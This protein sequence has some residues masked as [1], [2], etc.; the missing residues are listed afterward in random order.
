MAADDGMGMQGIHFRIEELLA[1]TDGTL[2]L[3]GAGGKDT[4]LTG[5]RDDSRVVGP[6]DLFLAIPGEKVDG[7]RYIGKALAAGAAAVCAGRPLCVADAETALRR[8]VP[9]VLVA[10]PLAAFQA[11]AQ[12]HRRRFPGLL[13]AG[14]T[15]SSGKTSTKEMIAAVLEQR[16]PGAVLKTE[17]NTNNHFGVPRNLLRLT[18]DHR[19]A[20]I[21]M[22]SN[23]P[24]EIALLARLAEPEIGVVSNIG[25]AHLEF[26]GSLEGVAR[27]K[28]DL[29]RHTAWSGI[30]VFPGEA[31]HVD[32]LRAGSA[33]R[34]T[35]T[36]G[37]GPDNDVRVRYHGPVPD[38]FR[39][40]LTWALTGRTE[41]FSWGIGGEHQAM[42]A[43]AAAAAGT[44]AGLSPEEIVKGLRTCRLPG[45]RM[46]VLS[47]QGVHWVN[48]AYN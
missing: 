13:V 21:E 12:A 14:I 40:S 11:L 32:V 27:E 47:W 4:L 48:D 44:A 43:A 34:R 19:A 45:M 41:T 24:G 26:F 22:G 23:H 30:A 42:N 15:G 20:V 16:S 35:L 7:H 6:G 37:S 17:G 5:V 46:S 28:G 36:F 8:G 3:P 9:I 39:V 29:L 2:A 1:L 18:G 33:P 10:D 38:G 25:L 31:A